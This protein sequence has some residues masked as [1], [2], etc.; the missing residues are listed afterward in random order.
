M[1][2][3]RG[4]FRWTASLRSYSSF[5]WNAFAMKYEVKYKISFHILTDYSLKESHN[6]KLKT[7]RT[8]IIRG[9]P[10]VC[11]PL[12]L[13]VQGSLT[14]RF[15]VVT[16]KYPCLGRG[17]QCGWD[18]LLP[19]PQPPRIL[20]P[21]KLL[22]WGKSKSPSS[23]TVWTQ[24]RLFWVLAGCSTWTSLSRK[25]AG[26]ENFHHHQLPNVWARHK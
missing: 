12:Q 13:H 18:L 9:C 20:S 25:R 8:R 1:F 17:R 19:R 10:C 21:K 5:W 26:S 16:L 6:D 23:T 22:L 7:F 3:E 24:H 15:L 4:W 2:F 14:F 11:S